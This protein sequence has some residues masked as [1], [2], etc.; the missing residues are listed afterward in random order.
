MTQPD[1][2]VDPGYLAVVADLLRPAKQLTYEWMRLQP[3]MRVLDVGCG[4]G[5]DTLPLAKI[6]SGNGS[7][8]GVD[9]D[10]AMVAAADE[11]AHQAG[12][13]DRV[14]HQ[15]G[16]ATHL[17]FADNE[18]DAT[19]CERMLLHI[20]DY[21]QAISEMARVTRPGGWVVAAETDWGA[22][23]IDAPNSDLERRL[24]RFKAEQSVH[25]GFSGRRLY[26]AIKPRG[27]MDISFQ[28]MAQPITDYATARL[29]IR[30]DYIEESALAAG[31]INQ[32]ELNQWRADLEN[33]AAAG[34]F[35]CTMNSV[36]VAGR[37]EKA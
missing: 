17:P 16:S 25:N 4:P 8:V 5:T 19:R 26:R 30:L 6:V 37:K 24:A 12:V 11:K 7:V 10:A 32:A 36:I 27:L 18:F 28:V 9:F 1:G 35:F 20:P 31:V 13:A 2:Y 21:E 23:S 3:G 29:V 22:L 34:V 33:A 14:Q 15:Q